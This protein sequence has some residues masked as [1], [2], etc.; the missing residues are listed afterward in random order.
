MQTSYITCFLGLATMDIYSSVQVP[1]A[2]TFH[3]VTAE[4]SQESQHKI[5]VFINLK[6]LSHCNY[7]S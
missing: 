5:F 4:H 3:R 6:Y 7:C 1:V 2:A